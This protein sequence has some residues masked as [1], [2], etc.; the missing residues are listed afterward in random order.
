LTSIDSQ[1]YSV[2]AGVNVTLR[3][4]RARSDSDLQGFVS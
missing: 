4:I 3:R 1:K 2:W